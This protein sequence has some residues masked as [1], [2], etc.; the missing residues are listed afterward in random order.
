MHDKLIDNI[1]SNTRCKYCEEKID[2]YEGSHN[3]II[4]RDGYT[5]RFKEGS[6]SEGRLSNCTETDAF[7]CPIFNINNAE[8]LEKKKDKFL[9]ESLNDL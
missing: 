1:F 5:C 8:E 6:F 4:I 2:N 7:R 3:H 9:N